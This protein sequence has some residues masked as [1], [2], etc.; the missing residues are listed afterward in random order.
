MY[1]ICADL[2]VWCSALLS[3]SMGRTATASQVIVDALMV[4]ASARG[5]LALVISWGMLERLNMVLGR[6]FG[7][8]PEQAITATTALASRAA[9]GPSL[10]LGGVGVLPIHDSED[11]HVLETGWAGEAHMLITADLGGFIQR[12]PQIIIPD[13]VFRLRRGGRNMHVAH[14]FDAA[15]WLRGEDRFELDA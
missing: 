14:T 10:S 2:N 1:R 4:G 13:R 15:A 7:F 6:E 5:P 12:D 9:G 8:T 3:R 11:R